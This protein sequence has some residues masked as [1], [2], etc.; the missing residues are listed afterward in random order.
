MKITVY[1]KT[2]G[3]IERVVG[4]SDITD[5][6]HYD[7]EETGFVVGEFDD[8]KH[9]YNIELGLVELIDNHER[10]AITAKLRFDER[11]TQ[12]RSGRLTRGTDIQVPTYGWVALQGRPED[13]QTLA[14][15][16]QSATLMDPASTIFFMDRE[17]F[18]H[19]MNPQQV[20]QL[21]Q[22]G[23]LYIQDVYFA[24]FT[25][26]AQPSVTLD[27]HNDSYWPPVTTALKTL[28]PP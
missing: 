3:E 4:L 15:L 2:T 8:E 18:L 20:M 13:Q 26:K 12:E 21:F 23:S 5:A 25:M 22:L 11:V 16:A 14:A 27:I 6:V 24:S 19:E 17:N 9:R 10:D 1:N 28:T 7:T